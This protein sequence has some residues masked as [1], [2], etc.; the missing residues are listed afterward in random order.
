L[1]A[2]GCHS[3]GS[4]CVFIFCLILHVS[5]CVVLWFQD[6]LA[7]EE[8]PKSKRTT[9]AYDDAGK[10]RFCREAVEGCDPFAEKEQLPDDLQEVVS[11]IAAGT[12]E[13]VNS[14]RE[15][16]ILRLEAVAQQL[17]QCGATEKW[18]QGA[19][20][21]IKKA[22]F[23]CVCVLMQPACVCVPG[24]AGGGWCQWAFDGEARPTDS[25]P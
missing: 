12:P 17:R 18:F 13:S 9:D 1:A 14:Y 15:N 4:R 19:D 24:F 20:P 16:A 2:P 11:W 8:A 5:T 10:L 7:S 22:R 25:L 21:L 3:R 23:L 6:F